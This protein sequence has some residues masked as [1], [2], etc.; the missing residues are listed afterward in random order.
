MFVK[1][2]RSM[3]LALLSILAA[4]LSAICFPASAQSAGAVYAKASRSVGIVIVSTFDGQ[5]VG[6]GSAVTVG[7]QTM[8]TNRHVLLPGYRYDVYIN[9]GLLEAQMGNCDSAQDLCLLGVRTLEARP[10][11]FGDTSK[12]SVGDTVY[13]IGA[14]NEMGNIVGVSSATK[15]KSYSPPQLTLSNGLI[16]ALRPVEDGKIIQT[17]AAISPGSS[18]GGLFDTSGRLLGI[19]TFAMRTG[20]DLNMALPVSWVERLGVTGAPHPAELSAQLQGT[21]EAPAATST[22]VVPPASAPPSITQQVENQPPA[23]V[24]VARQNK[25]AA[26]TGSV[27]HYGWLVI[28]VALVI[29]YQLRRRRNQFDEADDVVGLSPSIN[30]AL[31]RFMAEAEQEL[32]QNKPD[33]A[34]WNSVTA[35]SKGNMDAA[36]RSYI[37]R[38]AARL[39]SD[40]KDKQ[41]AAAA[42]QT[43]TH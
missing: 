35:D 3:K 20:Q 31:Q 25:P 18:G 38:R 23:S 21:A 14:P 41:W 11:E 5:I 7:P 22:L 17:N 32:D 8:V 13:T 10:V 9:G 24:P 39:L 27:I 30:P 4:G 15:Q 12:L 28:P 42:R 6:S 34:L 37:S 43:P 36:R 19:T 33:L 2:L 29:F 1:S 26:S 40:E 16:T